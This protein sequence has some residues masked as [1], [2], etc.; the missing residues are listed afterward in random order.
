M[1]SSSGNQ[2]GVE[3]KV[4]QPRIEVLPPLP[5]FMLLWVLLFVGVALALF[6]YA[7]HQPFPEHGFTAGGIFLFVGFVLYIA[8]GADRATSPIVPPTL[9][10]F[11]GGLFTIIGGR[12]MA[13]TQRDVIVAPFSGLLLVGGIFGFV[14]IDWIEQSTVEQIGNFT[15]ASLFLLLEIYLLFRGLVVGVQGVTWSQSGLRQTQRGLIHG[16][17]GAIAHFERSWDMQDPVLNV[18]AHAALA[19]I[20]NKIGDLSEAEMHEDRLRR[21]GGWDVVDDSWVAIIDS[22]LVSMSKSSENQSE[23]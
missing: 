4:F 13:R 12:H 16:P 19:R 14:T 10:I 11:F 1:I 9:A 21:L 15:I 17:R 7:R 18:M 2:D 20:H 6:V 22:S 5:Q 23:E 8:M 3:T